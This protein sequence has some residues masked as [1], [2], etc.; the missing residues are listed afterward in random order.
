[1]HPETIYLEV[2]IPCIDRHSRGAQYINTA[3]STSRILFNARR[4]N[5][6]SRMNAKW[7]MAWII[8]IASIAAPVYAQ[9]TSLADAAQKVVSAAEPVHKQAE[10]IGIDAATRTLTLR[11]PKG[12][13][14]TAVVSDQVRN[15][16]QLKIGDKVDVLYKNALLVTASKATGADKGI[17]KRVDTAVY[18]PASGANGFES[19]RQVEILATVESITRKNGTITLRG[20]WRTDTFDIPH[21]LDTKNLKPGDTIHAVFVSAAAVEV[22]PKSVAK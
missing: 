20:P 9:D 17:R 6:E 22:T 18:A 8:A 15:F 3:H 1:M 4:F 11:G 10:I 12:A 21:D 13:T 7:N 19:S 14:T 5:G 16:D 2:E